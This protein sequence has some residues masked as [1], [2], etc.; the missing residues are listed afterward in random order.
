MQWLL[1]VTHAG[2]IMITEN[3]TR[4]GQILDEINLAPAKSLDGTG[5][6]Q[7]LLRQGI[8]DRQIPRF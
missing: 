7:V 8:D 3:D 2:S 6:D 5:M 1:C 4:F